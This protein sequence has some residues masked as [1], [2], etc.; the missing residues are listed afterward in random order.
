[1]LSALFIFNSK[2]DVLIS[3]IRSSSDLFRIHVVSSTDVRSPV[4]SISGMNFFHIKHENLFLVAVT[5]T[6]P[7]AALVYE[8]LYRVARL[9]T[10]YFGKLHE[11]SV[12][13]NFTLI[14]ELLD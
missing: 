9:G 11:E 6:N 5:K 7:N 4:L 1:M 2:G 13:S 8:F 10:S 14:Y 3:R 12:K